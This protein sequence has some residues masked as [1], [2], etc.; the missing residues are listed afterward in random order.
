[1]VICLAL[2]QQRLSGPAS[3]GLA[4]TAHKTIKQTN[5]FLNIDT[6]PEFQ[7]DTEGIPPRDNDVA[8]GFFTLMLETCANVVIAKHAQ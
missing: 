7:P 1:M 8:P 2:V 5:A 4:V 6:H 3:A